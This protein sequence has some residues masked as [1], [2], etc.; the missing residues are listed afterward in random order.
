MLLGVVLFSKCLY[1]GQNCAVLPTDLHSF[2]FL[3]VNQMLLLFTLQ[4]L[5]KSRKGF[6]MSSFLYLY[7]ASGIKTKWSS[8]C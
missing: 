4:I 1:F 8:K 3:H 7:L 5:H 2:W 6:S